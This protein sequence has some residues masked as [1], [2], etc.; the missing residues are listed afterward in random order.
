MEL[1]VSG[2][3]SCSYVIIS[4]IATDDT[5]YCDASAKESHGCKGKL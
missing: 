3:I 1:I 2:G 5:S 4:K